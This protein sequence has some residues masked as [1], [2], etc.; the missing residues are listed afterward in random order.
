[1]AGGVGIAPQLSR[2]AAIGGELGSDHNRSVSDIISA[3]DLRGVD[4]T[5][6]GMMD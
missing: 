1:M 4:L 5:F 2:R 3:S 6:H